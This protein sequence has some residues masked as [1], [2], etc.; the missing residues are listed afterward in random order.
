M[1]ILFISYVGIVLH[2]LHYILHVSVV[3]YCKKV[4]LNGVCNT[5]YRNYSSVYKSNRNEIKINDHKK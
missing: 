4:S 2:K 1:Q 3:A 5:V